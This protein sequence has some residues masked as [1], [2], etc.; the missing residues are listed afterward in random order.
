MLE[1]RKLLENEYGKCVECGKI[2]EDSMYGFYRFHIRKKVEF[3]LCY[4]CLEKFI[5][6]LVKNDNHLKRSIHVSV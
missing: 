2:T 3:D 5:I 4:L 6:N 1:I